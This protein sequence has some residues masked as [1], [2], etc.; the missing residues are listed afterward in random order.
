MEMRA[1]RPSINGN[2]D[3]WNELSLRMRSFYHTVLML[4]K[5]ANRV[6]N[7]KSL[8]VSQHDKEMIKPCSSEKKLRQRHPIPRHASAD[9]C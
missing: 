4:D 2:I 3:D 6:T 8:I 1:A 9:N 7:I 5:E